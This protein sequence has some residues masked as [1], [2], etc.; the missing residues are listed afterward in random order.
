MSAAQSTLLD[1]A[2]LLQWDFECQVGGHAH[3]DGHRRPAGRKEGRE[4]VARMKREELAVLNKDFS[5]S[6]VI[7]S[8]C[9]GSGIVMSRGRVPEFPRLM[10]TF[11]EA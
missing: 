11:C 8:L 10:D 9:C 2:T 4:P 3:V 6:L 5:L 1:V 7:F